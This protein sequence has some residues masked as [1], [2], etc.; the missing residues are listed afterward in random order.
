[1]FQWQLN[2]EILS[3]EDQSTLHLNEVSAT[4]GGEYTCVVSNN[5]AGSSN[6]SATLYI[7]PYIIA[8]PQSQI[9]AGLGEQVTFT[10]EAAGFPSPSYRWEREGSV[11][12]INQNYSFIALQSSAGVY[13]CVAFSTAD[14][15]QLEVQSENGELIGEINV[16][17]ILQKRIQLTLLI[18]GLY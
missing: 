16:N 7:H 1:M 2:G 9:L 8:H 5:Y 6:T 12:S 17:V 3:D 13:S 14:S 18:I 4:D 15:L 11:V 10:C